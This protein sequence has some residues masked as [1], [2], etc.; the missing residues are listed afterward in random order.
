MDE[1]E[2]ILYFPSVELSDELTKFKGFEFATVVIKAK[3]VPIEM[4]KEVV[5]LLEETWVKATGFP[6]KAKKDEVM[7]EISH[8]VGDS[9]EV[10]GQQQREGI[11]FYNSC[12]RQSKLLKIVG[13][14]LRLLGKNQLR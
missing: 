10:Q 2:Y 6:K 8:L 12:L 14:L 3:V 13:M 1:D 11:Q 9:Q 5:S 4:E 7:K